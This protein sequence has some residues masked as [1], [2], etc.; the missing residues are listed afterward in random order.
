MTGNMNAEKVLLDSV[1][2]P[3]F[4]AII[5]AGWN[6]SSDGDV[7]SMTGHFSLTEIP[8]HSKELLDMQEA[9]DPSRL[10]LESPWPTPGW[11]VTTENSDGQIFVY[12]FPNKVW[13]ELAYKKLEE[14][15]LDWCAD[16]LEPDDDGLLAD[17]DD[18]DGTLRSSESRL[19]DDNAESARL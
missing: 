4:K 19:S 3:I 10:Y 17:L 8:S 12:Q 9:V 7:E 15:Y 5:S 13:A 1:Y 14:E 18:E 11:Y 16:T 6:V 2:D